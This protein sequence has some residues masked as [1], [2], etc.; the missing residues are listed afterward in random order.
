M[1]D[2][3]ISPLW[4]SVALLWTG[5]KEGRHCHWCK[6]MI[7]EDG[8]VRCGNKGSQYYDG[9]RI[10]TWNGEYCAKHCVVFELDDWYKSD[11][12][13]DSTFNSNDI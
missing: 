5:N 1:T 9:D 10:R 3:G 8:E 4:V 7:S 2:T 12:N 11:S 13:Y 6:H